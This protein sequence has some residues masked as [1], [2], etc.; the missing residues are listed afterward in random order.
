MMT[1]MIDVHNSPQTFFHDIQSDASEY[2]EDP[3][4]AN[5]T[6]SVCTDASFRRDEFDIDKDGITNSRSPT[7]D[8]APPEPEEKKDANPSTT[9][10]DDIVIVLSPKKQDAVHG[11]KSRRSSNSLQRDADNEPIASLSPRNRKNVSIDLSVD[12]PFD[13][14]QTKSTLVTLYF[15]YA[16]AWK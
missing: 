2:G 15:I 6:D 13:D 9:T 7:P 1:S 16:F 10:S 4:S 12:N 5:D 14:K 8:D 3:K 11:T